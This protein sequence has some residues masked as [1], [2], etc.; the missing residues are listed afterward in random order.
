MG[1]EKHERAT[2]GHRQMQ[3]LEESMAYQEA[4]SEGRHAAD[5]EELARA[6]VKLWNMRNRVGLKGERLKGQLSVRR[7]VS[8]VQEKA[9]GPAH[10]EKLGVDTR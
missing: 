8:F 5:A 4:L 6:E 1:L 10:T 7:L 3:E 2:E 9:R